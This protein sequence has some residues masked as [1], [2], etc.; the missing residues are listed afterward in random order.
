MCIACE[1]CKKHKVTFGSL[2]CNEK[3]DTS[4]VTDKMQPSTWRRKVPD[5]PEE[6]ASM[7]IRE[8]EVDEKPE[9]SKL[10]SDVVPRLWLCESLQCL[11]S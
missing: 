4:G 6:R 10:L 1:N 8:E 11:R 9:V 2:S 7:H 5:L 3:D